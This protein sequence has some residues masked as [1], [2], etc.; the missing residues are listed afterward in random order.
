MKLRTRNLLGSICLLIGISITGCK[1][2]IINNITAPASTAAAAHEAVSAIQTVNQPNITAQVNNKNNTSI[3]EK[4]SDQATVSSHTVQQASSLEAIESSVPGFSSKNPKIMGLAIH[5]LQEKVIAQ[6]G[7]P[8]DSFVMEDPTEPI[9]V[10]QYEG[11]SVGFNSTNEIQFI[12][13]SSA[14]V[15]P[16][17]NGLRLGYTSSQALEALGK[18]DKNS[19]YV[20]TYIT[21][22]AILKLDIDPKTKQIQSIKLFNVNE[23]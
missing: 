7:K 9:T 21:K 5:D 8:A 19:S 6:Y 23:S 20:M 15:N 4:S 17:L 11:F 14:K 10:Y 1:S 2:N 18:P 12:D 13:V 3:I 16:G 22:T